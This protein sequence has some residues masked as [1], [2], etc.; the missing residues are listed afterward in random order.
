MGMMPWL[1]GEAP[2]APAAPPSYHPWAA[3]AQTSAVLAHQ[4]TGPL[5]L[6]EVTE[7]HGASAQ[8]LS[9]WQEEAN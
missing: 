8:H 2:V 5:G 6:L 1:G 3:G 4:G 7:A 9:W